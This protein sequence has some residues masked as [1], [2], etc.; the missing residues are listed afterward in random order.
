MTSNSSSWITTLGIRTMTEENQQ[1]EDE[2]DHERK[3]ALYVFD[4]V[5]VRI[6]LLVLYSVVF[7]FC[8]F[9]N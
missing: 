3:M 6:T 7:V 2:E 5:P 8:F 9:G 1:A 4:L